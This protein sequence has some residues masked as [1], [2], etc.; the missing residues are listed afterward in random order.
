[1]KPKATERCMHLLFLLSLRRASERPSIRRKSRRNPNSGWLTHTFIVRGA[2]QI[3]SSSTTTSLEF[4][5]A[6]FPDKLQFV[7]KSPWH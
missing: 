5:A 1:M 7:E 6:T 4:P 3:L 2:V